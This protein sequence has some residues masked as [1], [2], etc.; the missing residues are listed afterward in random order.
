[1]RSENKAGEAYMTA[2]AERTAVIFL[3][4]IAVSIVF[5]ILMGMV[6]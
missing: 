3:T 2:Q 6:D 1:M 5:A 4:A